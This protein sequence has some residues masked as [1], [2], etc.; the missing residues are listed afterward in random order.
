DEVDTVNMPLGTTPGASPLPS[1]AAFWNS[2]RQS[3]TTRIVLPQGENDL[4]EAAGRF[5]DTLK[6]EQF[7][8]LDEALQDRV[9]KLLGGL[10]EACSSS[11]DLVR[12][13]ALP[14]LDQAAAYLGEHLPIT[15][16]AE[17]EISGAAAGS[18]DLPARI[19]DYVE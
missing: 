16:V 3:A 5:V 7:Q 8:Q 2:I 15:D 10:Y 18:H 17:V 4:E 9:L 14:L 12:A 13:V 19:R 1:T 11:R 6:P